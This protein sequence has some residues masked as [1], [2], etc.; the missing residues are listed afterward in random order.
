MT[1]HLYGDPAQSPRTIQ[2]IRAETDHILT[3]ESSDPRF[4]QIVVTH[5][6]D[7]LLI[8]EAVRS[9]QIDVFDAA[10]I[11]AVRQAKAEKDGII[12]PMTGFYMKAAFELQLEAALAHARREEKPTAIAYI[13]LDDFS[14]VNNEESHEHGHTV[15]R[16][17]GTI[18]RTDVRASDL[19]GRCGGEEIVVVMPNMTEAQAKKRMDG[20]RKELPDQVA[21][22]LQAHGITLE[23]RI[24]A[25]IGV[26]DVRFADPKSDSPT[27]FAMRQVLDQGDQR[28]RMA[29]ILGK[30]RVVGS[31]EEARFRSNPDLMAIGRTGKYR[32]H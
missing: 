21:A 17:L 10:K 12:D 28:M 5:L 14:M 15:L 11:L 19:T 20:L 24:T 6:K 9:Q 16:V 31:E 29:K 8:A 22:G 30:N 7:S 18:L 26:A 32:I 13:D 1:E 4:A 23:K 3:T 2:H 27:A 25:S